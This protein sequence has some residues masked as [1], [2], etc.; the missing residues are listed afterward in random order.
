MK[1]LPKFFIKSFKGKII[2]IHPSLLP[3]YK[4]LNTFSRVLK[5]KDKFSGCTVHYVNE[6][7]DSG[8]IILQ[9]KVEISNKENEQSLK[10]KI[11]QKEYKA[12]S[13]AIIKI[14]SNF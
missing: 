13:E 2:N 6:K 8:K 10:I 11:Q 7:L 3:K 1:I 12:Y 5:S 14:L 9:K 4:G